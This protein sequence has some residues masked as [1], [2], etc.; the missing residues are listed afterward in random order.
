MVHKDANGN[1][2]WSETYVYDAFNR[3]IAFYEDPDGPLG[4]EPERFTYVLH[5]LAQPPTAEQVSQGGLAPYVDGVYG[6]AAFAANPVADF[7]DG[8][9]SDGITPTLTDRRLYGAG[10]DS[11]LA[12]Q[13]AAGVVDFAL[14]DLIGSVRAWVEA[15]GTVDSWRHYDSFGTCLNC[16]ES[17]T[18]DPGFT[19]RSYSAQGTSYYFRAR[20][21]A[22][23][24]G[25]MLSQD[26]QGL[27]PGTGLYL[28]AANTQA[29]L[30][31]PL[32]LDFHHIYEMFLGGDPK[33]PLAAVDKPTHDAIRKLLYEGTIEQLDEMYKE[34]KITEELYRELK[35]GLHI[36]G[37]YWETLRRIWG[38]MNEKQ[39]REVLIKSLEPLKKEGYTDQ[40]IEQMV[41][42][43][44]K[45]AR[46]GEIR[47]GDRVRPR[48]DQT[49]YRKGQRTTFRPGRKGAKPLKRTRAAAAEATERTLKKVGKKMV[50]AAKLGARVG[51]KFLPLVNWAFFAYDLWT[52]WQKGGLVGAVDEALFWGLIPDS[53]YKKRR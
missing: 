31:D 10:I 51:G 50:R 43:S 48:A 35:E 3:R 37:K 49:V 14:R 25:R 46:P 18:G 42:D 41:D 23:S 4:P 1:V 44:M 5:D 28:Y 22:P 32:G 52:G 21:Y 9:T 39:H 19:A 26:P 40:M 20:E 2:L 47:S 34:G 24:L 38:Y 29:F 36:R 12:R 17:H 11:L 33:G 45:N 16:G 27:E 6:S 13:D 7:V 15:D 8:D 53:V 30:V